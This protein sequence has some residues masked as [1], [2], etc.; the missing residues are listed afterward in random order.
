MKAEIFEKI[1][2]YNPIYSLSSTLE[3][4]T[5]VTIDL[6]LWAQVLKI[7]E[8]DEGLFTLEYLDF[9]AEL[10]EKIWASRSE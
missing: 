2:Q 8:K 7:K 10:Q 5:N 6:L 9:N 1:N 3:L 4:L